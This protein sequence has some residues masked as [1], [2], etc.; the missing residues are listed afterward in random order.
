MLENFHIAGLLKIDRQDRVLHIPMKRGL[1]DDLAEDWGEQLDEFV[2]DVDEIEFNPAYT[3][4]E[5]ERFVISDYVLDGPFANLDSG[6]IVNR[7]P[8][9]Q[10]AEHFEK[11]RSI[12][13]FCRRDGSELVLFQNFTKSR[14]VRPGG[15]LLMRGDTFSEMDSPGFQLDRRLAAVYY[16]QE[17]KLLF[18]SF[19]IANTFLGLQNFYRDATEQEI[20]EILD[21]AIFALEDEAAISQLTGQWFAKRFALLR[22]SGVL[23]DY[24]PS[25]LQVIAGEYGIEIETT[26]VNGDEQI[27]F[28]AN[29]HEAK[30]LLK[31]LNQQVFQSAITKEFKET[32]SYRDLEI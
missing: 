11:I 22:D 12:V 31:F 9:M 4:E 6:T 18:S 19:R 8:L 7:P 15:F 1:Q 27:I 29:K 24:T 13:G 23:D 17:E 14:V 25:D 20:T 28:P 2:E 10:A 30:T 21:H 16:P 5:G 3:P 32:N 26:D